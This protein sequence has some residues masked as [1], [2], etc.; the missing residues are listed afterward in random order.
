M[1]G[2]AK[3]ALIVGGS[4]G[5]GLGLVRE[6]LGRGWRVIATTRGTRDGEIGALAK[7]HGDS[8]CVET[9]DVT[10]FAGLAALVNRL[11]AALDLLF[12]SAGVSNDP[13][14]PVGDVAAE[15]FSR[16]ML[17]NA[18]AP[19]KI[20]EALGN[21]VAADGAIVAMTSGL[22]SVA[23]NTGGGYEVYRA[24]K[25]ALNTLLRC[26][27]ARHRGRTIVAMHPGWVRT[28][29]GG[30]GATLSPAESAA[31][32]AR[33]IEGLA[34]KPGCVFVDYRGQTIAW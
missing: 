12:V 15:E 31:G 14:T 1:D 3:T 26:Y 16:I 33:V 6:Y 18:L 25:A 22:G 19:L 9:F 29:M 28:D 13:R 27:A 21:R 17:T 23:E 2:E 7:E 32:M 24:S 10:D 4:R 11:G 5:L 30:A 20:I 34:G 8:L